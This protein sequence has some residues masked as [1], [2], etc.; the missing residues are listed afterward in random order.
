MHLIATCWRPINKPALILIKIEYAYDDE[1][2]RVVDQAVPVEISDFI[3]QRHWRQI[4]H[5]LRWNR[6]EVHQIKSRHI[7][8]DKNTVTMHLAGVAP[9]PKEEL[10]EA[11]SICWTPS[12]M[13]VSVA[14]RRV[15]RPWTG[16][17][18]NRWMNRARRARR[19]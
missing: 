17:W 4:S 15:M 7:T 3:S 6:L 10:T 2:V 8:A 9:V 16:Q 19:A 14:M 5:Q 12:V 18:M 11:P 1:C 13:R